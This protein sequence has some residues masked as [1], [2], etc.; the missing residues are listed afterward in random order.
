M[1]DVSR[2]RDENESLRRELN[3]YKSDANAYQDFRNACAGMYF[4]IMP[5]V[6]VEAVPKVLSSLPYVSIPD[7]PD[8]VA[9]ML[10]GGGAI[11]GAA[12]GFCSRYIRPSW[13]YFGRL[14]GR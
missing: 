7:A 3:Q 14:V 5:G 9:F 2:L 6:A 13:Q 10:I 1:E 4:G 12:A 11:A 8:G